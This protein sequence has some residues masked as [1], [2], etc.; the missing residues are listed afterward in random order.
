MN[1]VEKKKHLVVS[2]LKFLEETQLEDKFSE[3]D[4]E[5]LEGF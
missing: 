2:F 3:S 5:S 1:S 4:S